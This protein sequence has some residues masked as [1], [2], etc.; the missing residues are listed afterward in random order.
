LKVDPNNVF[1]L[2]NLAFLLAET[3]HDL[4]EALQMALSAQR[5]I[6]NSSAVADT[7]GWVYLKKGLTGSALQ[8][9][10]NNVR[11]D[12]KNPTYRYHLAAALLASGDKLRAKEELQKA[13]QSGPSHGDEPSIRQLLAKIG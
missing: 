9:F 4:D 3:G 12:P 1:A 8:V 13:L 7:L 5:L 6:K 10:Q 11:N 2:N